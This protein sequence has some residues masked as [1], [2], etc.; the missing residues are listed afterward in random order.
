MKLIVRALVLGLVV[1]GA[2]ACTLSSHVSAQ[3]A[4]ATVSHQVVSSVRPVPTSV[5]W[6]GN[7]PRW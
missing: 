4:S 5:P 2:A 3:T 1:T 7:H 6:G